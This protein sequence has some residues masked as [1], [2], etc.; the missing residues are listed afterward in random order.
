VEPSIGDYLASGMARQLG[1]LHTQ[2]GL[3]PFLPQHHGKPNEKPG[4]PADVI[5]NKFVNGRS[6]NCKRIVLSEEFKPVFSEKTLK[7]ISFVSPLDEALVGDERNGAMVHFMAMRN[8]TAP[9]VKLSIPSLAELSAATKSAAEQQHAS[10]ENEPPQKPTLVNETP[11]DETPR[12]ETPRNDGIDDELLDGAEFGG[13]PAGRGPGLPKRKPAGATGA[14][15]PTQTKKQK[16]KEK[17]AAARAAA[18]ASSRR[19]TGRQPRRQSPIRAT[20]RRRR[21][22]SIRAMRTTRRPRTI[23]RPDSPR[24]SCLLRRHARHLR[25]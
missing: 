2:L 6:Y 8:G 3:A 7:L 5:N 10:R 11:H 16:L 22:S 9:R 25:G 4:K 21:R 13:A 24:A 23:R 14:A 1:R 12:D 19:P 15:A 18:R 17:K 20:R